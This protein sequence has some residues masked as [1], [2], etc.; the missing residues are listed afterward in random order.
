MQDGSYYNLTPKKST[1]SRWELA[2]YT[3]ENYNQNYNTQ[4]NMEN[5]PAD[6]SSHKKA[7][8]PPLMKSKSINNAV[9]FENYQ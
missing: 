3:N 7:Y 1:K 4:F 2:E 5:I 8:G 6:R 9:S